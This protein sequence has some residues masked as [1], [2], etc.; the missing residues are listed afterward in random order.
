MNIW[1]IIITA[2]VV[3]IAAAA[4]AAIIRNRKKGSFCGGDCA[5]CAGCEYRKTDKK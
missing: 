5:N 1:D 2:A 4:I 3:V